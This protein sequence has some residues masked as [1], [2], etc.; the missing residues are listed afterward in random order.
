MIGDDLESDVLGAQSH[1]IAGVLVRTGMYRPADEEGGCGHRPEY[2]ID[3]IAELP[4][5]LGLG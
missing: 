1:G 2:V 4:T 3:S 5:L